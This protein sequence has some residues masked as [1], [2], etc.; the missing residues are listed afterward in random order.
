MA[1]AKIAIEQDQ[2]HPRDA[3]AHRLADQT[4]TDDEGRA[5]Q[6]FAEQRHWN[7]VRKKQ[8]ANDQKTDR[9]DQ[10]SAAHGAAALVAEPFHPL[11]IGPK[12]V[13]PIRPRGQQ[14]F[15]D[16]AASRGE[17]RVAAHRW[18]RRNRRSACRCE[19]TVPSFSASVRRYR[20]DTRSARPSGASALQTDPQLSR[21]G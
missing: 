10:E 18:P 20:E 15:E 11:D 17:R 4:R 14:S 13:A 8:M 5:R 21:K 7:D 16:I 1:L 3:D 12:G 19:G 6:H 9:A 2:P